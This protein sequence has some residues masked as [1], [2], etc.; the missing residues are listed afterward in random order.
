[1]KKLVLTLAQT[2]SVPTREKNP[3]APITPAEI[4]R[5]ICDGY[6]RGAAITHIHA[7]DENEKPSQELKDFKRIYD[8]L[9][10]SGCPIIRQ[11]STSGRFFKSVEERA[12]GLA[13]KPPSASL[14]TGSV[15]FHNFIYENHPDLIQ[16]LAE[17]MSKNNIKPEL[18]IFDTG[19]IQNALA[20]HKDGLLKEPLQFNFVMGIKGAMAAIPKNLLHCLEMLPPNSI[21]Q[22]SA[23]GPTHVQMSTMAIAL[24]GNVRVGIEDNLYYTKGVLATNAMLIDRITAI[25]K[26]YGRE[27]A[28]PDEAREIL[29][30]V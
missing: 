17:T 12:Q 4:V 5:D 8:L 22:V 3:H 23:I 13:L 30:L 1:M 7:R 9:D 21:W 6:E 28:T 20:L 10:A 27:L 18:E 29:G 14:T 19:M 2:G 15:N 26:V 24:G 25:A 16:F 11:I